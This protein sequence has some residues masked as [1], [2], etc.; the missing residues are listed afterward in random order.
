MQVFAH[1][2]QTVPTPPSQRVPFAVPPD[3][4]ELVLACLAKKPEDRPQSAAELDRRLALADVEPWTEA[5]AQQWWATNA[6]S[7]VDGSADTRLTHH[8][9]EE[10]ITRTALDFG[11]TFRAPGRSDTE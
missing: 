2:L 6:S 7:D 9:S 5:H 11:K 1:H 10:S 3:L 4:E 8:T